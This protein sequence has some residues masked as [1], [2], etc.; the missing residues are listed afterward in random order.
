MPSATLTLRGAA[1]FTPTLPW[2]DVTPTAGP[3]CH[4]GEVSVT[5]PCA[6]ACSWHVPPMGCCKGLR[7]DTQGHGEKVQQKPPPYLGGTSNTSTKAFCLSPSCKS[8]K[9]LVFLAGRIG[10][11]R[12]PQRFRLCPSPQ[13]TQPSPSLRVQS[14]TAG[15]TVPLHP[16]PWGFGVQGHPEEGS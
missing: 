1:Q 16:S 2:G 13:S 4:L 7:K 3:G 5:N 12:G 10:K 11:R 6:W 15:I 9:L 14:S 8:N